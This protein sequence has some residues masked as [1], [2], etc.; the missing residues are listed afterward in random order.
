MSD[1]KEIQERINDM[2][3]S[4]AQKQELL[5]TSGD[6]ELIMTNIDEFEKRKM[7]DSDTVQILK[8]AHGLFRQIKSR[9]NVE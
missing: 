8:T 4:E 7:I 6:L 5:N 9:F 1:R 3:L 2:Q